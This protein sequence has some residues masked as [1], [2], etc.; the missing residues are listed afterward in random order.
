MLA[1]PSLA[2]GP[3]ND[4]DPDHKR[5]YHEAAV[6]KLEIEA[7]QADD[8]REMRKEIAEQVFK[9]ISVQVVIADIA[10][11]T[12]GF[13]NGWEN[14]R[15]HHE[16]MVGSRSGPSDRSRRG[17]NALPVPARLARRQT[18]TRRPW[19]RSK[20]LRGEGV[21]GAPL[22]QGG[23]VGRGPWPP[24]EKGS[25][26]GSGHNEPVPTTPTSLILASASPQR[27]AI[28]ERMG[29]AF[30]VRP[31]DVEEIEEGDPEEVAVE[32]ALRKA[33]AVV[34]VD[35]PPA[36]V[37]GVDTVVTLA[38]R[39]Y[40]K[41]KDEAHARATLRALSGSTHTVLSGVALIE[42]GQ[43]RTALAATEVV[44]PNTRQEVDRLV[45]CSWGVAR[46]GRRLRD[47]GR[48]G[49]AGT[50]GARRLRERGGPPAGDAAGS[51]PGAAAADVRVAAP[52]A[53]TR[54]SRPAAAEHVIFPCK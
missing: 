18:S 13:W 42:D 11:L 29:L 37:L 49:R 33:R 34:E 23:G 2:I 45:R 48:R 52:A 51:V 39:V 54:E 35:A 12:Y 8:D 43:E 20:E 26:S 32:N 31:A 40:G 10:F 16:R 38:G 4:F 17:H 44:L 15:K 19:K 30:M 21:G 9:A 14:P 22:P 53:E 3:L 36:L 47:P 5:R 27:K 25:P 50:R 41:P 6:Q 24:P 28:L 7:K 46:P 1:R